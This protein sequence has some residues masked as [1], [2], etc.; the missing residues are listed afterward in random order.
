MKR[1]PLRYLFANLA[2]R[3]LGFLHYEQAGSR[4]LNGDNFPLRKT[5]G[6]VDEALSGESTKVLDRLMKLC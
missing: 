5:R 3:N 4:V 1:L 6:Q 2:T